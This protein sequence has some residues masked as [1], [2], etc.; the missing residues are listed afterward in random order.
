[1]WKTVVCVAGATADPGVS[2]FETRNAGVVQRLFASVA[3]GWV[4]EGAGG[5]MEEE[6]RCSGAN[7]TSVQQGEKEQEQEQEQ[8]QE[9]KE[10]E[11]EVGGKAISMLDG[12]N[13]AGRAQVRGLI[14]LVGVLLWWEGV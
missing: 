10:Q 1:M 13:V 7:Y 5:G 9:D 14:V 3:E 4:V 11:E 12:E 6:A 8:E 2:W